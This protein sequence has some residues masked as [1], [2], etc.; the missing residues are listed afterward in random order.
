MY[1]VLHLAFILGIPFLTYYLCNRWKMFHYLGPVVVCYL[2]GIIAVNAGVPFVDQ[3]LNETLMGVAVPLA[4]IQLLLSSD[5]SVWKRIAGGAGLSFLLVL[6]SVSLATVAGFYVFKDRVRDAAQIGGMFVG[7]YTGATANMAAVSTALGVSPELFGLVNMYDIV[8]GGLYLLFVMT[9]AQPVY[10]L[11]LR[12]RNTGPGG[13]PETYVDPSQ[14][15][16]TLWGVVFSVLIALVIFGVVAGLSFLLF[17][18][19]RFAFLIAAT[20]L[21]AV[22][23]SFIP[24]VKNLQGSFAAGDYF[25]L[26]FGTGAGLMSDFRLFKTDSI[27]IVAYMALVLFLSIAI[28]IFLAWLFRIDRDTAIIT[29]AAGIMSAPFVPAIARSMK[30]PNIILPGIAAGILGTAAGSILGI[31]IAEALAGNLKIW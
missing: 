10:G 16:I 24:K 31:M 30:N 19:I 25:L 6:V 17:D 1:T 7:V 14:Q 15:P 28:H 13:T 22:A 29:S 2:F 5:F 23:A 9:V 12:V 8:C 26:V 18:E 27:E 20:T 3:K 11:F 21:L 4:I